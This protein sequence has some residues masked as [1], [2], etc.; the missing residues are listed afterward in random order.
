MS[1][2]RAQWDGLQCHLCAHSGARSAVPLV[3]TQWS[4]ACSV[5]CA[6]SGTVFRSETFIMTYFMCSFSYFATHSAVFHIAVFFYFLAAILM[7]AASHHDSSKFSLFPVVLIV[8]LC[9]TH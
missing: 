8:L 7:S 3:R 6:H 5:T 4:A 2:V 1:L 9:Y